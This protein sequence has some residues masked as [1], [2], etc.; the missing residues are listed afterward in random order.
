MHLLEELS[1]ASILTSFGGEKLADLL[2]QFKGSNLVAGYASGRAMF[3]A[4]D[5][6][7]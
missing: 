2:G 1:F 6:E 4:R 5:D 3:E 7:I